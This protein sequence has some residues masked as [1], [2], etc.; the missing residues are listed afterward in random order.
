MSGGAKPFKPTLIQR[1][2]AEHAQNIKTLEETPE[3]F[4]ADTLFQRR[5]E[6]LQIFVY[7][8]YPDN[9]ERHQILHAINE[10][11]KLSI[12]ALETQE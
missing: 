9:P 11:K 2:R 6:N 7:E 10:M 8:Q 5:M 1:L 4:H 12:K 3:H